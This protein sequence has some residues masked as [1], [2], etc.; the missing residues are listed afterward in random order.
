M[1]Y[2]YDVWGNTVSVIIHKV[3]KYLKHQVIFP[4]FSRSV[5]EDITTTKKPAS[6]ICS[7]DTTIPI[8]ADL[9]VRIHILISKPEPRFNI[10]CSHIVKM[11]R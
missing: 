9:L 10:I 5:T 4:L 7:Q 1:K 6:T 3:Y 2:N 11:T 8:F